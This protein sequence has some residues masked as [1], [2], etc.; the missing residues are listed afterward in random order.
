MWPDPTDTSLRKPRRLKGTA[1][2]KFVSIAII[3]TLAA[4]YSLAYLFS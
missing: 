3:C 4:G 1:A 2:N